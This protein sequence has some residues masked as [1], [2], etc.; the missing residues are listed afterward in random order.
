MSNIVDKWSPFLSRIEDG[1]GGYEPSALI[2]ELIRVI[3]KNRYEGTILIDKEGRIAFMDKPSEKLFGLPPGCSKGK[4]FSD[5]FTDLGLLEVLK[6][7]VPQVGQIQ[8]IWGQ[9]KVVTRFPV[10]KDGEIIGAAGRVVFNELEAI[11][12]L[13]VRVQKL[14]ARISRYKEGFRSVN[15]AR[16]TFDDILGISRAMQAV[17]ESARRIAPVDCTVLLVGESGTGKELFAHSIHQESDRSKG[18]FVRVNCAGIPFELA[19]SALFGYEKGAF[20]G[21]SS[22]GQ[23]GSF[24]LASG[25]TVFLDEISSMPLAIQGKLLRVIQEKEI[26]PLGAPGPRRVDFRLIAATNTELSRLVKNGSFRADLYYRLTSV[27]IQIPPLR[28]RQE[29]IPFLA[30]TLLPSVNQKLNGAVR[31]VSDPAITILRGYDW[32]GNVRELINILEQAVLNAHPATE[33]LPEHLPE[34]VRKSSRSHVV[35]RQK[36]AEAVAELERNGVRQA[37]ET[38]GGNKRQAANLL[39]ISRAALYK[40]MR[41]LKLG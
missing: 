35:P 38:T 32:P 33:I 12:K 15:R 4:P 13:S 41:R 29:D 11:K 1:L 8:E 7:G 17:K 25:G 6:S 23:K 18:P 2:A 31:S 26:Q 10:I 34:S 19:E 28:E 40:K 36:F 14:E 24:E 37:L 22:T 39:G 21:A 27:P 3:L 20:T 16:Y 9:Q 5:F 30:T